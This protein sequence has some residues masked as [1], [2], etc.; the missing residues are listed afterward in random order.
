ME[1]QIGQELKLVDGRTATYVGPGIPGPYPGLEGIQ[2]TL[3]VEWEEFGAKC[4]GTVFTFQ[5]QTEEP[6]VEE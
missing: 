6:S 1:F 2:E 4:Y 3:L 5:I